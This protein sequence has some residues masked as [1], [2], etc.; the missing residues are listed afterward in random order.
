MVSGRI[1]RVKEEYL[2]KT[3]DGV[4][5]TITYNICGKCGNVLTGGIR[6]FGPAEIQCGRC[7]TIQKTGLPEWKNLSAG[8]KILLALS[9]ILLPSWISTKGCTGL[10]M[11]IVTQAFLWGIVPAPFYIILMILDPNFK[12]GFT[13]PGLLLFSFTYPLLLT[14][15][16]LRLVRESQAYTDSR[17]IPIWGAEESSSANRHKNTKYQVLLRILGVLLTAAWI[18]GLFALVYGIRVLPGG[19][20]TVA[21]PNNLVGYSLLF[22]AH[23]GGA[24]VVAEL[25]RCRGSQ[26][27]G[28]YIFAFVTVLAAPLVL[29]LVSLSRGDKNRSANLPERITTTG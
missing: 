24:V 10:V 13:A 25:A 22:A 12:S 23:I 4:N 28:A 17:T 20:T 27:G 1:N 5:Y 18:G 9:E 19:S 8:R 29:P 3:E 7:N 14:F 11:N 21:F 6:R 2:M 26:K 15:R 16:V